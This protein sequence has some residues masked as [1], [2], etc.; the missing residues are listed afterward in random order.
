[1]RVR[2][3]T[4]THT[5]IFHS[6]LQGALA[7][8]LLSACGN[9]GEA[10]SGETSIAQGSGADAADSAGLQQDSILS[11]V[12]ESATAALDD[13][14]WTPSGEADLRGRAVAIN[15]ALLQSSDTL[16]EGNR[17]LLNLFANR[18]AKGVLTRVSRNVSD[19]VSAA[20]RIPAEEGAWFT[21]SVDGS[22]ILAHIYFMQPERYFT[23]YY[24]D[25]LQQHVVVERDPALENALPEHPP[26]VPPDSTD[27]LQTP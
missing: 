20:G 25:E 22:Q 19:V 2:H 9:S 18:R 1:M 15:S 24:S 27:N 7:F 4:C 3:G 16:A 8:L 21:F 12:D 6:L 17:L 5:P 13:G 10:G 11:M 26:V 23:V 14:R